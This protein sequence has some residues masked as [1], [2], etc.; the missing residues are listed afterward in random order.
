MSAT[1][2]LAAASLYGDMGV[3]AAVGSF[4]SYRDGGTSWGI[5]VTLGAG[6]QVAGWR[7]GLEARYQRRVFLDSELLRDPGSNLLQGLVCGSYGSEGAFVDHR[8]HLAM[9]AV[10]DRKVNGFG[11]AVDAAYGAMHG[12]SGL[13]GRV[14]ASG[15]AIFGYRNLVEALQL[16]MTLGW[17][18]R[19]G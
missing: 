13:F 17:H 5:P 1:L 16:Y 4:G 8:F 18:V 19:F 12:P 2:L 7:A 10:W 14:G 11:F 3:G 15:S 6:L 9:G